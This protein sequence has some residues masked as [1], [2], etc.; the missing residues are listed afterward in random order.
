MRSSTRGAYSHTTAAPII[1]WLALAVKI[2]CH[3]G[4]CPSTDIDD[5]CVIF[6]HLAMAL[7]WSLLYYPQM[8]PVTRHDIVVTT[9]SSGLWPRP[10]KKQLK[11]ALD[12]QV[13]MVGS[14]TIM[15]GIRCIPA[16][17]FV[18]TLC[19]KVLWCRDASCLLSLPF[20][21]LFFLIL[22]SLIMQYFKS[23]GNWCF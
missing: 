19:L 16:Q 5:I 18:E 3:T 2:D 7:A 13:G 22:L 23:K 8:L 10:S 6:S 21:S 17:F 20:L 14:E 11:I 12:D 9:G 15:L 1:S 4:A